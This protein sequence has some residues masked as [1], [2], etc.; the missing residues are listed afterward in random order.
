MPLSVGFVGIDGGCEHYL[1][2]HQ[3]HFDDFMPDAN[4]QQ[5]WLIASSVVLPP[6]IHFV[7][8]HPNTVGEAP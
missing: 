7:P 8:L 2:F 5:I 4:H 6:P 3:P 1:T